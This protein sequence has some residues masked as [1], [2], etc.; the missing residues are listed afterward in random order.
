M[1]RSLIFAMPDKL[2]SFNNVTAIP[3]L[4]ISSI[5]GN[6][7][8]SICD[9]KVADLVL[10]KHKLEEYVF[11]LLNEYSPDIV[12]LS[13]MSFQYHSA[14]KLA[15]LIKS[16]NRDILV[17]LGGY[18]PTLMFDEISQSPESEFFDFIVRG[19]GEATFNELLSAINSG[20]GYEKI[21]GLSFKRNGVFQHNPRR[22]LLSL[23]TIKLPN[24]KARLIPKGFHIFGLPSDAIETSRGCTFNC[25]FCSINHMYGRSFRV[26]EISRVIEDIRDANL[27]GAKSI[28]IMDDNITLDLKRLEDLCDEIISN[29]LNSIHYFVQASVKGIAHSPKL[30]QKMADAGVKL[31]FL[32]IESVSNE[33]LDF[34]GKKTTTS[35]DTRKAVKYLRDNGIICNGGI[36][37]GN[38]DDNEESLW[39]TFKI[40]SD[41]NIDIPIFFIL[42]PHAK[43]QIREELIE[44]GMVTNLDDFST[45]DGFHANVRTRYLTSDQ[46]HKI[47]LDMYDAYHNRISYVKHTLVRKIYPRYFWKLVAKQ[48]ALVIPRIIQRITKTGE[49]RN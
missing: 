32:G 21:A 14:V 13:C 33:T 12:G 9:I 36:I 49:Y 31:V 2:I 42:T 6:V 47:V 26:Y 18:H 8:V 34:L 45:Y 40:A 30:V 39:E 41:L 5:A 35:E 25:K 29:K 23:D 11:N 1:I 46:L 38:P 43:T 7:D 44:L 48:I 28:S 19:E 4:G 10:I 16:Y 3:N 20:K 17:A 22:E 24:R 15:K 27:N 37:V